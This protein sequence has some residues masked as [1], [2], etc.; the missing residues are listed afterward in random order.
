[1][2][3]AAPAQDAP[4]PEDLTSSFKKDELATAADVVG[5]D[6]PSGATKQDLAE[7]IVEQTAPAPVVQP[8]VVDNFTRRDDND[9]LLGGWVDVVAGDHQGRRGWYMADLTNDPETGYPSTVL[10]RTRDADSIDVDVNYA[11]IRPTAYTGGR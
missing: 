11:D 6:V 2:A 8:V 4:T 3:P 5:A 9:A 7:A 10:V 1:V